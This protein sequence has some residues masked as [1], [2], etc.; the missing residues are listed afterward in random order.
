MLILTLALKVINNDRKFLTNHE[1]IDRTAE[2]IESVITQV[3][4]ESKFWIHPNLRRPSF[5]F[6]LRIMV[7]LV[8]GRSPKKSKE[9]KKTDRRKSLKSEAKEK[10]R[11]RGKS[12]N[13]NKHLYWF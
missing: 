2:Q 7:F 9:K 10:R 1:I 4:K 13:N 6:L 8:M 3:C 5:S 12:N 11:I